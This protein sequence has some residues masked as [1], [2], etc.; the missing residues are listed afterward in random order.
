MNKKAFIPISALMVALLLSLVAA[1][2]PFVAEDNSA[3]AQVNAQ[4]DSTLSNLT[5]STG[6]LN[7]PLNLS[8]ASPTR[9]Y[10]ASVPNG[11]GRITVSATPNILGAQV[12][13]KYGAA[14][15]FTAGTTSLIAAGGNNATGGSVPLEVGVTQIGIEV[16]ALSYA[17]TDDTATAG[18]DESSLVSVYTIAVTRLVAGLSN[19]AALTALDLV[20]S[21]AAGTTTNVT[22][23]P[24]LSPSF[25]KTAIGYTALV[26]NITDTLNVS[27][28]TE[29]NG[30]FVIMPG[31]L[32]TAGTVSLSTG[33]NTITIKVTSENL[34]RTET[35]TLR[36]TRAAVNASDDASLSG[37]SLSRVTLSPAFKSSEE[38]YTANVPH[39]TT[40]TTVTPTVNHP[41]A[42]VKITPEDFNAR[43]TGEQVLLG[44]G[45][46]TITIAVTAENAVATKSYTVNVTRA[47]AGASN[48]ANLVTDGADIGLAISAGTL[49]PGFDKDVT[50]YTTLVSNDTTSVTVTARAHADAP[51]PVVTSNKGANKVGDNTSAETNDAV[52]SVTLDE[53]INVITID[54]TAADLDTKK[55][56]TLTVT[57]AA[58]SASDDARLSALMVG[59]EAVSVAGFNGTDADA[60]YS[61]GVAN[62]VSS[63]EISATPNHSG[64]IVAIKTGVTLSADAATI[65]GTVDADGVVDLAIGANN[66]SIEVTPENGIT[67]GVR[68][69]FLV[70]TRA[71]AGVSDNA[72]LVTDGADIG[73]VIS[74]GTLSP[75]FDK[76]VTSYTTLVSNGTTSVTVTARAHADAPRP[77]VTSNKGANKVGDNTSAE[78]NDAVHPVTLDE[79]INVITIDVTAAD[80]ATKKTYTLTVTRAA[81]NASDDAG[82]SALM[83]DGKSVSLADFNGTDADA[84]YSTGVANGV[85]SIEI[86]ATPNH[87]GAIV[88]IKT[89]VTLSADPTAVGGDVDADGVV[90]VGIGANNISIEVTAEDGSTVRNY[91]LVITRASASASSNAKLNALTLSGITFSPAFK[92]A[93][94]AYSAEVPVNIA[95]TT[96][97]ATA[98]GLNAD[99]TPNIAR[100]ASSV[101]IMSDTDDTLGDDLDATNA[102]HITSHSID[103]SHGD[104][105][106]TI[107]VTAQDYATTNTYTVRVV[108]GD[109]NNAYLS[110]LSLMDGAGMDVTLTAGVEAHWNTLNCP[111]MNDRVG[112]DDQP[113]N[114]TSP[115]CAMYDGLDDDAKAVVDQT[116]ADDPIEGFMSNIGMY[117]ANVANGVDMVSVSAMAAD[118][119]ATVDGTGD[120]TLNVGA[121]TVEVMVTAEDGTT[122]MTYK[123]M[124]NRAGSSDASLSSLSLMGS[125]GMAIDLMPMFASDTMDYTASVSSDVDMATVS[126]M[127]TDDGAMVDVDGD[128]SLAVGDNTITVTVTA[129]DG[130]T[131]TYTITV[132]VVEPMTD[133]ER[134]LSEHDGN[135]NGTIDAAELSAA[136]PEYLAGDISPSDMRILIQLYL[137]G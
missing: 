89:G 34:V 62:G 111:E 106:I 60:D 114:A 69:Y 74:T 136:I 59:G 126:A 48:N 128:G 26:S 99:G 53:G 84:D 131:M 72:N 35:Y 110:S 16:K 63:I 51:R 104:N 96:I 38:A 54:V 25:K 116:Y 103:L 47:S 124:V 42:R 50:S 71:A 40:Q 83:V 130:M 137:Q 123:V 97:V 135:G 82:L 133:E 66:I 134:L 49:S 105:V 65:G 44:V 102:A 121:N 70:V 7:E 85:S 101:V 107:M 8:G 125:D 95:S 132:T 56:Y 33:S 11:T 92:A 75:G 28:T 100:N 115:Y 73:L 10:T 22:T 68:N 86:S 67:T 112:A 21:N 93:T 61:T 98:A 2:T 79:G 24:A 113:D 18:V 6:E 119:D 58:E 108:R 19:K 81:A 129:E 20:G 15:T 94:M 90:G 76:D 122:M 13:I 12:S 91:F 41:G 55:A 118:S 30:T 32:T 9:A 43:V 36:V 39:T 52:H 46:N 109:S 117:Y 127:A 45:L 14:N 80:L 77:V 31:R 57:R 78:T 1:M 23:T 87:S 64:A 5:L 17:A 29:D 120:K 3:Y 88:A 27:P 4:T 37:L